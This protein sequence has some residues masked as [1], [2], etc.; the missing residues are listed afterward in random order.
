MTV[1]QN[2]DKIGDSRH[3]VLSPSRCSI[4]KLQATSFKT[5]SPSGEKRET[6]STTTTT[7][8]FERHSPEAS[9]AGNVNP[10]AAAAAAAA[11]LSHQRM[12]MSPLQFDRVSVVLVPVFYR[13]KSKRNDVKV[14]GDK[15]IRRPK[16]SRGVGKGGTGP[17]LAGGGPGTQP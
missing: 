10:A 1:T 5:V 12:L 2:A 11:A 8:K 7:T 3:E 13:P 4:D 6:T 16:I 14:D 15:S 9:T 17:D